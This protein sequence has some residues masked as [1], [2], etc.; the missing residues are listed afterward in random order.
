MLR[1]IQT[2]LLPGHFYLQKIILASDFKPVSILKTSLGVKRANTL[3]LWDLD[4]KVILNTI[5][6]SNAGGIKDV[7]FIPATRRVPGWSGLSISTR[8]ES[9]TPSARMP[10]NGK[11]GVAELLFDLDPKALLTSRRTTGRF[12]YFTLTTAIHIAAL[13][14]SDLGDVNRLDDPNEDQPTVGPHHVKIAPDRQ[15]L[16]SSTRPLADFRAL[17]IDI[18]ADGSLRFNRSIDFS[19][20]FTNRGGGKL[21][22]IVVYDTT[23]PMKPLYYSSIRAEV[24][25]GIFSLP[26][27]SRREW[28]L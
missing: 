25:K 18:D 24:P 5:I 22:S 28:E 6:I 20:E 27:Q 19:K 4:P 17:Y 3:P 10:S 16:G 21:H 9:S 7:H 26:D 8:S 14:I 12:A 23:D 2:F 11:P 13:D 15:H 1:N